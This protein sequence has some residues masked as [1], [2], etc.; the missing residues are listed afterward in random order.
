MSN[1]L[2]L[3]YVI[4]NYGMGSKVV[5]FA[6]EFN[7]TSVSIT[8]GLGSVKNK[9]LN[10]LSLYDE[11]KE[12]VLLMTDSL[13]AEKFLYELNYKFKLYQKHRG[14]AFSVNIL[15]TTNIIN[16]EDNCVY[17]VIFTIV[18][19]GLGE[20]VIDS[21]SLAGANGGTI[22]NGRG[23]GISEKTGLLK[24]FNVDIEPEKEIVMIL[25][26]ETICDN[27]VEKIRTDLKIDDCGNGVIFVQ[28]VKR[29]YGL[30]EDREVMH[31]N[32]L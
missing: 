7:V 4:V 22:L 3:I 15:N 23:S 17:N 8:Y 31:N 29:V 28:S 9:L 13:N 18:N 19:K 24:V 2:E 32:E 27:V 26:N 10:F 20:D 5:K 30:Y 14:I 1:N 12:I 11:R 6:H 16:V 25:V 21:A